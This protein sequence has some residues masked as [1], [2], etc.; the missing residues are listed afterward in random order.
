MVGKFIAAIAAIVSI[1]VGL[2]TLGWWPFSS[3][4]GP[5]VVQA[6]TPPPATASSQ[7][8]AEITLSAATAPRGGKI[9]VNG[10]GF[11]P[12]ETV[13]IR[14][15]VTTVGDVIADSA[16]Q[17]RQLITIPQSAPPPGFPTSVSATGHSSIKTGTA[18]FSTS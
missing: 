16:G 17:F 4:G 11:Q 3:S 8:P 15:H 12:G 18:P 10:S 9:T 6:H 14:V 5:G 1:A 13:E 2:A 7:G